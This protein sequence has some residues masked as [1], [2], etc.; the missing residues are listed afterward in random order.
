MTPEQLAARWLADAHVYRYDTGDL[1]SKADALAAIARH[2]AP[3]DELVERKRIMDLIHGC[4]RRA[5]HVDALVDSYD[6][7]QAWAVEAFTALEHALRGYRTT[8]N[9]MEA[10]LARI[11]AL[12]ARCVALGQ[13][14][15][16]A[17][18]GE[19]DFSWSIHQ[20]TLSEVIRRAETAEAEAATLRDRLARMEG[21]LD[22]V[23]EAITQHGLAHMGEGKDEAATAMK[24]LAI[25]IAPILAALTDGGS[26]G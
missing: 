9:A 23:N 10:L 14:V 1:I 17:R 6:F 11:A 7:N 20:A 8:A 5:D 12:E 24:A 16:L 4:R 2:L 21:A 15:N 13:E 22:E 3:G 25:A 19:R 26:N 18:Y